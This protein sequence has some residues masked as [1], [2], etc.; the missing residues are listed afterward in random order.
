MPRRSYTTQP[1]SKNLLLAI[2]DNEYRGPQPIDVYLRELNSKWDIYVTLLVSKGQAASRKK[3]R[4]MVRNG[5]WRLPA[6][7][8]CLLDITGLVHSELTAA[9]AP[10]I[11]PVED[12]SRPNPSPEWGGLPCHELPPLSKALL[13]IDGCWREEIPFSSGMWDW[14]ICPCPSRWSSPHS[15]ADRPK[16][17]QWVF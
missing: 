13:A 6:V 5:R 14:R 1:S 7:K 12:Q 10:Y 2:D 8:R 11:R 17:T 4:K 15:H 3:G 16:W 9:L